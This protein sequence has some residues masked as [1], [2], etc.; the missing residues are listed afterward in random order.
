MTRFVS[1]LNPNGK[2]SYRLKW[3]MLQSPRIAKRNSLAFLAPH[4]VGGQSERSN[5]SFGI[6]PGIVNKRHYGAHQESIGH[7]A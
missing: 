6:I 4:S 5:P 1:H 3:P 2:T 7:D